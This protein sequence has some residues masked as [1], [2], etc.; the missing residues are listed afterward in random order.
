MA[1]YERLIGLDGHSKIPIH[2]FMSVMQEYALGNMTGI[3]ARDA[4]TLDAT[5]IT[6]ATTLLNRLLLESSTNGGIAR[7]VKAL[8]LE[9]VLILAENQIPPYD[10]VAA[11]KTRLGV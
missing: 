9:N 6:E 4:F 2:Q 8:E 1:L 7:R 11:V 10:T 5:D 3:Q